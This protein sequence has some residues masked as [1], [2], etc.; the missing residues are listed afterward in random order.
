M[1]KRTGRV[2]RNVCGTF[3]LLRVG[4]GGVLRILI[5][6]DV[7]V[8]FKAQ[9][10][11][12]FFRTRSTT[13]RSQ[14]TEIRN[15]G[16]SSPLDFLNFLQWIFFSL[17]SRF[18]VQFNKEITPKCGENCPISGR[19]KRRK[20]LS[21]LWLSWFFRSRFLRNPDFSWLFSR[22]V[23]KLALKTPKPALKHEEKSRPALKCLSRHV[24][25]GLGEPC[26]N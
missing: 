2:A 1:A 24:A 19:R 20:I 23:E 3:L 22:H 15:F 18:Y 12:P 5:V 9:L 7:L 13:K 16:A 4:V 6:V 14:G 25:E 8:L 26:L 11:D 17:F 10:N 21:R